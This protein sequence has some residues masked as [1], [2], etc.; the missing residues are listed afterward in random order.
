MTHEELNIVKISCGQ[1][2]NN[3]AIS[4]TKRYI[5]RL[6]KTAAAYLK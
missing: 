5:C 1:T 2:S 4:N 3:V 6:D